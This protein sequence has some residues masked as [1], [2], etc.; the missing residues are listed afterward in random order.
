MILLDTNLFIEIIEAGHRAPAI[1]QRLA[2][3]SEE[4]PLAY[5]AITHF[6]IAQTRG[7]RD[8]KNIPFLPYASLIP[9]DQ[10]IAEC[11][12]ELFLNYFGKSR[13]KIPDALIAATSIVHKAPLWTLD[14]DFKK[15]PRLKLF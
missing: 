8:W 12:A 10:A 15:V 9:V 14:S 11:A 5:S 3:L 1:R 6:E 7:R 4:E 13:R 2:T